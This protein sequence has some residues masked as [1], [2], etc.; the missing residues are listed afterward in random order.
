MQWRPKPGF[1]R[2]LLL[3]PILLLYFNWAACAEG[4]SVNGQ[5]ALPGAQLRGTAPGQ[6]LAARQTPL[7]TAAGGIDHGPATAVPPGPVSLQR[8]GNCEVWV[9]WLGGSGRIGRWHANG[10]TPWQQL[11]AAPVSALARM[12]MMHLRAPVDHGGAPPLP[13]PCPCRGARWGGPSCCWC[14]AWPC[15]GARAAVAAPSGPGLHRVWA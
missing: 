15:C 4:L 7:P 8:C 6:R 12:L 11:F 13:C 5:A 1:L 2:R 3:R 14:A 10:S 9:H